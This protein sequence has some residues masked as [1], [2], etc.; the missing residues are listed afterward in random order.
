[1]AKQGTLKEQVVNLT[2]KLTDL[3]IQN[4]KLVDENK[5]LSS[6]AATAKIVLDSFKE[7][8]KIAGLSEDAHIENLMD[9][10]R[11]L[12]KKDET[13]VTSA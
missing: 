8:A 4:T 13:K 10:I 9:R 5:R 3:E 12:A 1:M 11:S 6:T 7:I 2:A